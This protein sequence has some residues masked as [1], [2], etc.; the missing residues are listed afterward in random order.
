MS[1]FTVAGVAATSPRCKVQI[2]G[3]RMSGSCGADAGRVRKGVKVFPFKR[4]TRHPQSTFEYVFSLKDKGMLFYRSSDILHHLQCR[5]RKS[6]MGIERIKSAGEGF[7]SS[8][9]QPLQRRLLTHCHLSLCREADNS[10]R[11]SICF[12]CLKKCLLHCF[13]LFISLNV[14]ASM[15]D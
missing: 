2:F 14:L 1:G 11:F 13:C 4:S 5:Y 12:G 10:S 9:V 7:L 15:F 3:V 8:S 6:S